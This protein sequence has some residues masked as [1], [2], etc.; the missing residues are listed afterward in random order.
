MTDDLRSLAA[1]LS[2][3]P[4]RAQRE[5]VSVTESAALRLKNGWKDNARQTSGRHAPAYP[6]SITYDFLLSLSGPA[7]EVGP[8]KNRRQGALGNLLEFGSVRNPPHNDG[9]RA[10]RD[11]APKFEKALAEAALDALGWH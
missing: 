6:D 9:G 3:A 11:E 4:R 2:A 10:L 1:D 8:D 5:A 7:V